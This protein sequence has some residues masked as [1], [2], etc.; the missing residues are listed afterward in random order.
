MH[1]VYPTF[2]RA[3]DAGGAGAAGRDASGVLHA[4]PVLNA[5]PLVSLSA[6]DERVREGLARFDGAAE[7]Y[8]RAAALP[9]APGEGR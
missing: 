9:S 8:A 2:V 1:F 4:A 6:L 5:E 7:C 3:P